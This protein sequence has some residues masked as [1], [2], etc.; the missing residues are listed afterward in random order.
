MN[1]KSWSVFKRLQKYYLIQN[2]L[3]LHLKNPALLKCS[4]LYNASSLL[5]SL[6]S[7]YAK[8]K[9]LIFILHDPVKLLSM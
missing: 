3:D 7:F 8:K 6:L 5:N 4:R 1:S 9:R 2:A